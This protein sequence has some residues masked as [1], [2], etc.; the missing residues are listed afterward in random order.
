[1]T[2]LNLNL[3]LS[4]QNIQSAMISGTLSNSCSNST[5][6]HLSIWEWHCKY[7]LN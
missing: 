4:L 6:S 5:I 1:M 3:F 2:A 7:L